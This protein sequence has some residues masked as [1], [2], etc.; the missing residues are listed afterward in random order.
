MRSAGARDR[1]APASASS[2]AY[3]DGHADLDVP[4]RAR[5]H[6]AR[7]NR[8]TSTSARAGEHRRVQRARLAERVG[9]RQRAEHGVARR[10]SANSS[11]VTRALRAAGS[12]A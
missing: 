3:I 12:R 8:G 4:G 6:G 9:Q 5:A 2:A 7:S 1:L 11:A 10:R